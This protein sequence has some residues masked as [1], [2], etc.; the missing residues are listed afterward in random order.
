M[1][2][3]LG[4]KIANGPREA[5]IRRRLDAAFDGQAQA[6]PRPPGGRSRREGGRAP[7]LDLDR[8]SRAPGGET[9][10]LRRSLAA[11]PS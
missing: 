8:G 3:L 11:C 7:A 10:P 5:A 9:P 2:D 1:T 6:E 4:H